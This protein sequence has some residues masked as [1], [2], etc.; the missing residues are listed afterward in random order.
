MWRRLCV[1]VDQDGNVLGGSVELR[2]QTD[3]SVTVIDVMPVGW[4][5]IRT[6][7]EALTDLYFHEG[8]DP[9]LFPAGPT[10]D[11]YGVPLT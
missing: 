5:D 8:G 9:P 4:G 7:I 6:P 11:P 10:R 2:E 3:R 1:D